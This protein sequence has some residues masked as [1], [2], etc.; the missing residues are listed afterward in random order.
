MTSFLLADKDKNFKRLIDI[1]A[2][3]SKTNGMSFN[4]DKC[5]VMVLNGKRKNLRFTLQGSQL[6]IVNK[7]KYIASTSFCVI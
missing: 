3:W 5:K 7:Y 6:E 1:C 4:A 2:E